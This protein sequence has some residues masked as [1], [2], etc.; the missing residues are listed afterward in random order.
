VVGF[1]GSADARRAAAWAAAL[2]RARGGRALHLVHALALP[3][4]PHHG[5]D[6]LSV[7][8]LLER[9]EHEMRARLEA[10]RELLAVDGLVVEVHLRRWS[11]VETLIEHAQSRGAGLV[12]V[13]RHG[14][15]ASRL[16]LGSVSAAVARRAP[17][18]VVVVRGEA[19]PAPPRLALAA[20]DG[21]APA[22]AAVAALAEWAPGAELLAV[23]VREATDAAGLDEADVAL[24][25]AATGL[26]SQRHRIRIVA[27]PVAESLLALARG[28]GADLISA[29][30]RGKSAW[31][32]LLTG[33]VSDKLLQLSPCPVL[34]AH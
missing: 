30:R 23:R 17:V 13:G 4:I 14:S 22:R 20:M 8:E 25:L 24:D 2:A 16:V 3:A 12:V 32:E 27:G 1:D 26:A 6:H 21:S 9:H 33:S 18:P 11:P 29:G 7:R 19:R 15:G 5:Y 34:V 10:E 28:E 31:E